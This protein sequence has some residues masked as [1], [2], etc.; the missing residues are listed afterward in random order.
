[1]KEIIIW[2]GIQQI[3]VEVSMALLPLV[4][5]FLIFQLVFSRL[6]WEKI[7][8]VLIGMLLSFAGLTLFLQGVQIGFLPTGSA[9]GEQIGKLDYNWVVI[10][11]GLL[12]GFVTIIA[13]PSVRVLN[14]EVEKVSGGFISQRTMMYTLAIGVAV[15]V[16][17]AMF[18]IIYGIPLLYIVVPGYIIAFIMMRYS[19]PTLVSVAFDAG[20]VAT[21]PM[22]VTFIMAL[23]VGVATGIEGR[24][25]LLD[26][27]G[28]VAL[29]FLAPILSVLMLGIF[30]A[31]REDEDES[32]EGP[33]T[34]R[35]YCEEGLGGKDC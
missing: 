20:A 23:A 4:V 7:K 30:Y 22:T 21:G 25:P 1:M 11:L 27:F 32:I 6:P 13:E 8:D 33:S 15:A 3:I 14:Y 28:L 5:I 10:P 18:K 29:A 35:D 2:Q 24:D 19:T 26:G 31:G 34:D 16:G 9:I 12:I 17:L